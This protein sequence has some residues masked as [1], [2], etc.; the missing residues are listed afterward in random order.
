[1]IWLQY[2]GASAFALLGLLVA[3]LTPL[4]VPGAWMLIG[5]AGT[6]DVT[7]MLSGGQ[8]LPFG[9]LSL[10]VAVVAAVVGELLEFVASSL[11]ARAGGAS[12]AGMVGSMLG[13]LVGVVAGTM[14]LPVPVVGTIVGAVVG[15]AAGA[16]IGETAVHGR[17]ASD[18]VKPATGAVIGRLLGSLVKFPCAL[19][20]WGMLVW[21]AFT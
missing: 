13:G 4:G 21:D 18:A 6:V 1:M 15:V 19:V 11:G 9:K 8:D 10:G 7:V 16:V 5:V 20:A 14:L 12:R 17:T 3:M 2:A